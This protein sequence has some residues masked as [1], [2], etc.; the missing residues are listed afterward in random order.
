[1]L[2][3]LLRALAVPPDEIPVGEDARAALL[4][5]VLDGRRAL[6]LLDD[7]AS[8]RQVRPILPGSP[9]C[10]VVVTSRG[11]LSGLVARD[12]AVPIPL[13][14]LP[15]AEAM[16]LLRQT[17][18]AQRVDAAPEAAAE[19]TRVCG[20]LPLALRIAADRAAS[21]QLTELASQLTRERDRLEVLA[22][23]DADTAVRAAFSQSYRWLDAAA[24]RA[25]RLLGLHPGPELS[26]PAAAALTG[27]TTA[28]ARP[29]LDTLTSA[30]LLEEA[31]GDRL[32]MHGLLAVY[33]RR[34]A[35]RRT[36][37]SPGTCTRRM[38]PAASFSRKSP[39][40][41]S[42]RPRRTATR[43]RSLTTSARSAGARP[44]G[45]TS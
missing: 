7:A 2:D 29:A 8:P 13:A 21:M 20:G 28:R 19:I 39:A 17:I 27:Q 26:R 3:S 45:S 18:G 36:E 30:H 4:R 33:A 9:G 32:R 23:D 16:A 11:K 34:G 10:V 38:P 22:T 44:N 37:C 31:S 24:A 25:F 15:A 40:S 35:K 42:S 1:M 43:S 14:P 41:R 12:G 5:T 6:I